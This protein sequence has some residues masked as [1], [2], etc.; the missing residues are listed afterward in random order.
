MGTYGDGFSQVFAF[1]TTKEL[2]YLGIRV[3][4]AGIH[5]I[6]LRLRQCIG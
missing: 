6:F 5:G 2:N 1:V 3:A 4:F